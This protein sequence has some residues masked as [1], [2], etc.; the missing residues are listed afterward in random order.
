MAKKSIERAK[1]AEIKQRK[2]D[3]LALERS[4]LE[5]RQSVEA[6]KLASRLEKERIR[7]EVLVE[8]NRVKE[9]RIQAKVDAKIAAADAKRVKREV[10]VANAE[11][12]RALRTGRAAKPVTLFMPPPP[13]PTTN[14]STSTLSNLSQPA[15]A[16]N[17]PARKK[18]VSELKKARALLEVSAVQFRQDIANVKI[19]EAN[20]AQDMSDPAVR[21]ARLA[22]GASAEIEY[23][24]L[25]KL[26][27]NSAVQL[28]MIEEALTKIEDGT[29]GICTTCGDGIP[30]ERLEIRPFAVNCT[31][32][33]K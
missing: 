13:R 17:I 28:E 4:R 9:E 14:R 15:P 31:K 3:K 7:E 26:E 32:C 8:K 29:Y 16:K 5:S 20:I 30:A 27:E 24:Q 6:A 33:T 19:Q 23:A 11:A 22:D 2:A 21:V 18:S 1:L 12:A 10:E 25:A